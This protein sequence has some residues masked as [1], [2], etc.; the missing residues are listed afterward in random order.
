MSSSYVCAYGSPC[1]LFK[2]NLTLT[3]KKQN[4]TGIIKIPASPR[5]SHKYNICLWTVDSS[6]GQCKASCV[7]PASEGKS[8]KSLALRAHSF[9]GRAFD[10]R[11]CDL[12]DLLLLLIYFTHC[13]HDPRRQYLPRQSLCLVQKLD[14]SRNFPKTKNY[15]QEN[16]KQQVVSNTWRKKLLS[17]RK[18]NVGY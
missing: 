17:Y 18:R 6:S 12:Q 5:L 14:K 8:V 11:T 10:M 4:I 3:F 1:S 13:I 16:W 2:G 9:S 15:P 7:W